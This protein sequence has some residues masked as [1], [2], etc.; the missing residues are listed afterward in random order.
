MK[1]RSQTIINVC[2]AIFVA[3]T[4]YNTNQLND[5]IS[6][7]T[8]VEQTKEFDLTSDILSLMDMDTAN[9]KSM[10]DN[11][12]EISDLQEVDIAHDKLIKIL[13]KKINA[14]RDKIK[15]ISE[16]ITDIER[17]IRKLPKPK[18]TGNIKTIVNKCKTHF[19]DYMGEDVSWDKHRHKMKC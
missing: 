18:T 13:D 6:E 15:D 7:L 4:I 17:S 19:N 5:K 8:K 2:L 11:S 14:Q 12:I 9:L 3:T 1:D 16:S 10:H